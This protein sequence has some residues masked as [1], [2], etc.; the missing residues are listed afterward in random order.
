ME[1]DNAHIELIQ[2]SLLGETSEKEN[3]QLADLVAYNEG[4]RAYI[5]EMTKL[6]TLTE[7]RKEL[8]T[9]LDVEADYQSFLKN[10]SS[11]TDPK[12]VPMFPLKIILRVAAVLLI[13]LGIGYQ[14][15]YN[16]EVSAPLLA[17]DTY[18]SEQ[19]EKSLADNSNVILNVNSKLEYP[20]TFDG[21]TRRVNLE[22]EAYF[23]IEPD[24]TK[25]FIVYVGNGRIEVKG[26]KF[27][28]NANNPDS[29][30]VTVKE[31]SV[32]FY[33]FKKL[34]GQLLTANQKGTLMADAEIVEDDANDNIN[35]LFWYDGVLRFKDT[36]L[37]DVIAT[38]KTEWNLN[39]TI[40]DEVINQCR[41]TASFSN[42]EIDEIL[43]ML[44][45]TLDIRIEKN[46][47]AMII[48]GNAC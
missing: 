35:Y 15:L 31:G 20:E 7:R 36:E 16:Q 44:E 39:I 37:K 4:L 33:S 46:D 45:M 38:L 24:S 5:S 29:I 34:D 30:V 9:N 8:L 23:D 28:V 3:Q 47:G 25:P 12:V 2:K 42:V 19:I 13:G 41:V 43:K 1:L 22:G 17:V 10:I 21:K 11:K 27:N 14:I 40:A 32:M 18:N 6:H 48:Y 26:T